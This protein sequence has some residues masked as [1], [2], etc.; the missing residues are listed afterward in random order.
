MAMRLAIV[1]GMLGLAAMA[2]PA[3]ANVSSS[4]L[5]FED[6]KM[7]FKSC[8]GQ[9]LAARWE[10]AE[11][12]VSI[13]GKK[14]GAA[15]PSIKYAG[16]DGACR[17]LSWD[18]KAQRFVHSGDKGDQVDRIINY[19][20]WDGSKWTATRAGTGFFQTRV[21]DANAAVSAETVNGIA[22]WLDKWR[23]ATPAASIVAEGL[24]AT[25]TQ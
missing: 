22:D 18:M 5:S 10:G 25:Q 13:P 16:W 20:G 8:D 3:A 11:F 19:V 4:V 6:N 12:S 1:G 17:T 2:L 9:N 24:R 15:Q 21:A 14:H 23:S 7:S